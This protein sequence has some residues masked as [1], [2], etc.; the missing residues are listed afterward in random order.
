MA[1]RKM[2]P[3]K[4]SSPLA[5]RLKS[6]KPVRMSDGWRG[7]VFHDDGEYVTLIR[8]G[9]EMNASF[10]GHRGFV[11]RTIKMGGVP[12]V[13]RSQVVDLYARKI[14]G[15]SVTVLDRAQLEAEWQSAPG[16]N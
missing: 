4:G 10:K 13:S 1:T 16:Y 7:R 9:E 12:M 3:L 11:R 8:D 5:M 14:M 2:V 15:V 6:G